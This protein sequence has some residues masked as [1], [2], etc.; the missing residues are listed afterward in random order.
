M[1]KFHMHQFVYFVHTIYIGS[2]NIHNGDI[3][4][5]LGLIWT[6]IKKYQLRMEGKELAI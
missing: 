5:V 1:I 2:H 6:L 4:L 3:K